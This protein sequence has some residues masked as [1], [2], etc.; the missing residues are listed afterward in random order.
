[1]FGNAPR[2]VWQRWIAPDEQHRIPLACRGFVWRTGGPHRPARDRHR[3]VLRAGHAR[4]LRCG[5]GPPRLARLA[6]GARRGARRRRRDR[7]V[8]LAL[9]SRR[10]PA[11]AVARGRGA[12]AGVPARARAGQRGGLGPGAGAPRPRSRVVHPRAAAAARGQRPARG[13]RARR[14]RL[15]HARAGRPLPLQRRAH[16]RPLAHRAGAA[17]RTG[18]VRG[19]PH[20]R[21]GLGPP[22][23]HDG[24]RPLPR[25]PHRREGGAAGRPWWRAVAACCSPTIP[26]SRWPGWCA[27]RTAATAPPT[28]SRTSARPGP[29][30]R[31]AAV[32]RRRR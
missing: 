16:A 7:A 9:R 23:D 32:Y 5:R 15:R 28:R 27:P 4:P 22:A 20:P 6:G 13:D 26:R 25:A 30:G 24:L 29:D 19:R 2:A 1:M 11:G 17:R 14:H 10:R 18:A 3:R 31:A 12:G 8:A 21:Q